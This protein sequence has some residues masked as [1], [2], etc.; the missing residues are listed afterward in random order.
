MFRQW[1][2]NNSVE[3][4]E[5]FHPIL[6]PG[7]DR[8]FWASKYKRK[9]IDRAEKSIGYEWPLIKASDFIALRTKGSRSQQETPHFLRRCSLCSLVIGEL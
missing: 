1:L 9:Y 4:Y 2:E 5:W 7:R 6:R 3:S 8:E